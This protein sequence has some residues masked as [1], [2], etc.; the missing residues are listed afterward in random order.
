MTLT[1]AD[2][3]GFSFGSLR[4][5]AKRDGVLDDARRARSGQVDRDHVRGQLLGRQRRHGDGGRLPDGD[6]RDVALAE[7]CGDLQ[8]LQADQRDERRRR[9]SSCCSADDELVELEELF[10]VM[11][12]PD[13]VSPTT[14]PTFETVPLTGAR[15]TV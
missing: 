4:S 3:P 11:P 13:T 1:L 14:P 5:S 9:R 15:S 10:A 8:A 7:R 12:L 6:V 2:M